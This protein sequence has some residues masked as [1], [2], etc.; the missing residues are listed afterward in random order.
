MLKGCF[1]ILLPLHS[2]YE[3]LGQ[4]FSGAGKFEITSN[5]FLRLKLQ[6]DKNEFNLLKTN[7]YDL[8]SYY[9][10]FT[11][12]KKLKASGII[13]GL[14]L[15]NE[16][17]PEKFRASLKDAAKS[18]EKQDLFNLDQKQFNRKLK[19]TIEQIVEPLSDVINPDIMKKKIINRTK[20]LLSG[21]KEERN[22]AQELLERLE[23]EEH[24][25]ISNYCDLAE[26]EMEEK[27]YKKAAKYFQKATDLSA[28]LCG[29]DSRITKDLQD[30]VEFSEKIPD[31][32]NERDEAAS[33]A[34]EALK[35]EQFHEAYLLY[36]K[37]SKLSKELVQFDKEEEYRLKAKALNE[38]AK[39]DQ[40]FK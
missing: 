8:F 22:L 13:L 6:H 21:G 19:K 27:N 31:I 25:K 10:K 34:R 26:R 9:H 37:A 18:L 15:E 12:K 36:H 38:F 32:I 3:I 29:K 5:I 20:A 17:D 4:Y 11:T 30:R 2:D 7:K 33:E 23:D 35:N 40:M 16:E 28:Q 14:Y 1:S 39:V 24:V